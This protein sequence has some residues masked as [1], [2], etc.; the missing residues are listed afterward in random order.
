MIE[1]CPGLFV[2][3]CRN[4]IEFQKKNGFACLKILNNSAQNQTFCADIDMTPCQPEIR[5]CSKIRSI[6]ERILCEDGFPKCTSGTPELKTRFLD[7]GKEVRAEL[8][9]YGG[10]LDL[11]LD[12]VGDKKTLCEL[13][14][15]SMERYYNQAVM[16][17]TP[18][19]R[20]LQQSREIASCAKEITTW[21]ENEKIDLAD[22]DIQDN[23]IKATAEDLKDLQPLREELNRSVSKLKEAG[24]KLYQLMKFHVRFCP[25]K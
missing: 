25:N 14:F 21:V 17:D 8:D 5:D 4:D 13:T 15:G 24:P 12:N 22:S 1:D 20:F 23:L 3:S 9:S 19:N 11:D 6:R 18:I 7:L 10:V 2:D 16:T